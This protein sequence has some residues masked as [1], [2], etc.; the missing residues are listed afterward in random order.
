M[1][2]YFLAL[3]AA[4]LLLA[5]PARAQ[6]DLIATQLDSATVLMAGSGYQP[7]SDVVRGTLPAGE[8]EEFPVELRAGVRYVILGVCDG[9]CSDVDLVLVD[10]A[11]GEAGADREL[12]D[13]P[14]VSFQAPADGRYVVKVEMATCG[15]GNCGYGVRVYHAP[16][17]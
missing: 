13:V 6:E 2:P 10:A 1:K 3:A 7:L 14:V 11:G 12:D 8:D 4:A 5:A 9:G 15:T 17:Q 16:A